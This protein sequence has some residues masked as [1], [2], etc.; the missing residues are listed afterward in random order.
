SNEKKSS[1]DALPPGA[2]GR[3]GDPRFRVPGPV[4]GA[5]FVDGGKKLLVRVQER[6]SD[7][8][9]DSPGT[10][11]L[12]DMEQ[13]RELGRIATNVNSILGHWSSG[14]PG[15]WE[16]HGISYSDW[17]ISPDSSMIAQCKGS[18][19]LASKLEVRELLT[20]K[21]VLEVEEESLRFT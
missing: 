8:A 21:M 11:R 20:G 6:Q 2:F 18:G 5:R 17:A 9:S 14:G 3:L 13:G 19:F 4:L 1:G 15:G 7:F 16:H 12:F 10:F